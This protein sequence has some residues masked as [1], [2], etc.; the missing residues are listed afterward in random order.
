LTG[1]GVLIDSLDTEG[2]MAINGKDYP[3]LGKPYK[4]DQLLGIINKYIS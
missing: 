3:F 1:V 4:I 2:C